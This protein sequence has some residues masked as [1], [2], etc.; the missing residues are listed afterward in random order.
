MR[1]EQP[2]THSTTA[3]GPAS[4]DAGRPAAA[5]AAAPGRTDRV[6]LSAGLRLVKAALEEARAEGTGIRP[7]AVERG[8]ALI[9]SGELD[10]DLADLAA[11]LLPDLIDSH[12]DDAS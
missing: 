5:S 8:K 12:D 3:T 7:D 9:A 11:R 10:R 6:S 1:I 2:R 4:G